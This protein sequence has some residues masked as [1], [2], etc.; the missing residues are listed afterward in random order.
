MRRRW[1]PRLLPGLLVLLGFAL[2][3]LTACGDGGDAPGPDAGG[4]DAADAAG[5]LSDALPLDGLA[6]DTH[7]SDTPAPPDTAHPDGAGDGVPDGPAAPVD[8]SADTD[9]GDVAD[10]PLTTRRYTYRAVA[11]VSMG[12]AA[13]MVAAQDLA[14]FDLVGS[15]GGYVDITYLHHLMTTQLLGGFCPMEQL[16]ANVE[17][18]NDPSW[19]GVF[20]G[21]V[22][23]EHPWERSVDFN[24]WYFSI[25]GGTVDRDFYID[26]F[27]D[28]S[29]VFGSMAGYNP[30]SPLM[31]PGMTREWL[32]LS[33]HAKCTQPLSVGY[34]HNLNREY[35]P[36]G[37]YPLVTFCDGQTPVGCTADDP[38]LCGENN[39]NY[40]D[41]M[42]WYDPTQ[43]H[44]NPVLLMMAVDYNGNGRRDYG[45]PVVINLWERFE[46]VGTDGCPDALE[47]GDGTCLAA[48]APDAPFDPDTNPDPNGDNYDPD[49]NPLGTERNWRHE[50]GEPFDDD[51]LDG[52]P[53]PTPEAVDYGE[54]NDTW[55]AVPQRTLGEQRDPRFIILQ[56][57]V[58]E[59]E[60]VDWWFDGGRRDVL[61]S[62][63][64][65]LH[66]TG[67]LRARGQEVRRYE[68][69]V[70]RP[71]TLFPDGR[72]TTY[73]F[74][75]MAADLSAA[76]I[77]KN[78]HMVYGDP[79][80]TLEQIRLGD[81][82]HVGDGN[83]T[84]FRFMTFFT[85]LGKR[86]PGLPLGVG[87]EVVPQL[88]QVLTMHTDALG[89]RYRFLVSL[90]PGYFDDPEQRYPVLYF[91]HGL[92][93]EPVT[94]I[95]FAAVML[96]NF[97]KQGRIGRYIIVLP[98][99]RCCFRDRE[100]GLRECACENSATP[101]HKSCIDPTCT[102]EH[103]SCAW[104][105]VPNERLERECTQGSFFLNLQSDKWG[106][107]DD[108]DRMRYGDALFALMDWVDQR[109]RVLPAADV[110]VPESAVR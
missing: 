39:P 72:E 5:V 9:P 109:Y 88:N 46:D 13:A 24:H 66:T 26:A 8:A 37:E 102:G 107:T 76:A 105:D 90:P 64:V 106:G 42:G 75:M 62:A 95:G 22:P 10:V 73:L 108:L 96:Q 20:C 18:L 1:P 78:V 91:L 16:V 81:G 58:E 84:A 19:P 101:G 43:P 63:V 53:A 77:G 21:P 54:G 70:G 36:A 57:P 48:G 51:G 12:G 40:W 27:T 65:S 103:E 83:E 59:L 82:G 45:E 110:L 99:G 3:G 89:A 44:W 74:D 34:P 100:T 15:L 52:V 55:D 79:N 30:L 6:P 60:R 86:W 56:T 41:L 71:G 31:P 28:F 11:G 2:G 7:P 25:N 69:F 33:R 14:R 87:G 38:P 17:H 50:D 104:R 29:C 61:N 47:A 23:T 92:G 32:A 80:A 67:A 85:W 94:G 97:M 49:T 4:A 98:D 93:Q 68:D 35:N